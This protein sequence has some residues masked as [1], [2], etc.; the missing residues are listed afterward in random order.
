MTTRTI[1]LVAATVLHALCSFCHGLSTPVSGVTLKIAFDQQ[2]AVADLSETKSE[3]FTCDDSLDMVHRLRRVSDCV[4]VGRRTVERDDCTLTV[5][6]V[7]VLPDRPQQPVRVVVDPQLSLFRSPKLD[8]DDDVPRDGGASSYRMFCDG[9]LAI[10]YHGLDDETVRSF[11]I[12]SMS[13][14]VQL[15][16]VPTQ[17]DASTGSSARMLDVGAM[18]DD[19]RTNQGINHIMV[20]GGPATARAFLSAG[21]VDRA[22]IVVAPM[23]F[24]EPYHSGISAAVLEN[25]GLSL[26]GS[27]QCGD[28]E[29]HCWTKCGTEWPSLDDLAQWP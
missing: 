5:R 27:Y 19:M 6:R 1:V 2:W 22:I 16:A 28:D 17:K 12:P 29:V 14:T 26:L 4:L 10:V 8:T 21:L 15:V 11:S 24:I 9:L 20:E 25:A 18:M 23:T 3:R 13:N 7:A